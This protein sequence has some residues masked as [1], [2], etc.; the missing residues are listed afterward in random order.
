[1]RCPGNIPLLFAREKRHEGAKWLWLLGVWL[2]WSVNVLLVPSEDAVEMVQA[3][4][5]L[6]R[7]DDLVQ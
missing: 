6:V 7:Y 2:L 1:M 4:V 5:R 3:N